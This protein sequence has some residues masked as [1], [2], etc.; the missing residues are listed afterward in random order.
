[1][2]VDSEGKMKLDFDYTDISND[3]IAYEEQW[4]KKYLV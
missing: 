2:T 1:M 4:K 3:V